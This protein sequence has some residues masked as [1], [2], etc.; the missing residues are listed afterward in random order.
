MIDTTLNFCVM[1]IGMGIGHSLRQ[2]RYKT[3]IPLT[4]GDVGYL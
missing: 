4:V 1:D 2:Q 3:S